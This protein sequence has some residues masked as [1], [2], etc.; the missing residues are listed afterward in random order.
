MAYNLVISALGADI[1]LLE[2][3]TKFFDFINILLLEE[4]TKF[5]D[6]INIVTSRLLY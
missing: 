5:F 4:Q 6:F 3:Q 1:L 2:E